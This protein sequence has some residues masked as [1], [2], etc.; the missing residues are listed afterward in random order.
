MDPI[1]GLSDEYYHDTTDQLHANYS[2]EKDGAGPGDVRSN[3][4][5]WTSTPQPVFTR[6]GQLQQR[7]TR[8][9]TAH[10]S[11][12]VSPDQSEEVTRL[13]KTASWR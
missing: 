5:V 4:V 8:A 2:M 3:K 6:A 10:F 11:D 1:L 9:Q 13:E 12:L 7:T